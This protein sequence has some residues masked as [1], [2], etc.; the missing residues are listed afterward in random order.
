LCLNVLHIGGLEIFGSLG[1]TVQRIYHHIGG[2][3]KLQNYTR[4]LTKIY[5][6]I[7]GS[8]MRLRNF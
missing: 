8:E 5:H 6:H 4:L 3:E 7:G 1:V 2:L